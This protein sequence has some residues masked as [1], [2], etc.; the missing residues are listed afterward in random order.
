MSDIAEEP[1][2]PKKTAEE[3]VK[4]ARIRTLKS[5]VKAKG[6]TFGAKQT[7]DGVPLAHAEY[8]KGQGEAEI[9]EVS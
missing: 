8:L 6:F 2:K 3:P 9:L 1:V 5:G 4:L 7:V